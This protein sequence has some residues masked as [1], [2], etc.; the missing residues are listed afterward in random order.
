MAILTGMRKA[1]FLD[2]QQF[3]GLVLKYSLN[4]V[5]INKTRSFVGIPEIFRCHKNIKE[6]SPSHCKMTR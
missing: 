1:R 2:S 4:V 3:F 5:N 6:I